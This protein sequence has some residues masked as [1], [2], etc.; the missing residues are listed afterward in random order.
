MALLIGID[1]S[2]DHHNVR[3]HNEA[4]ALVVRFEMAH[5]PAGFAKLDEEIAKLGVSPANGLV[6]LETAHNLVVDFLWS[7]SYQVYVVAPSI[8]NRSRGRYTSSGAHDDDR[9]AFILAELLRTDL[10]RFAPWKPDGPLVRQMRA[11]LSLVDSL[12]SP[13]PATPTGS[14]RCCRGT[15]LR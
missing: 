1:W 13:S 8:V 9:D 12:P 4:G 7:R 14:T 11:K 10:H 5:S 2:Q 6:A 3:I 15:I